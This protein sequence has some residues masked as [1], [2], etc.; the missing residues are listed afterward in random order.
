VIEG[1]TKGWGGISEAVAFSVLAFFFSQVVYMV[2]TVF[3]GL[4]VGLHASTISQVTAVGYLGFGGGTRPRM[5][6]AALGFIAG[7]VA[8][9]MGRSKI[10]TLGLAGFASVV[11]FFILDP[12]R[13]GDVFGQYALYN[14]T[15]ETNGVGAQASGGIRNL[16]G[17]SMTLFGDYITQG[18]FAQHGAALFYVGAIPFALYSKVGKTTSTLLGLF[19]AFI[20]GSGFVRIADMVPIKS[21]ASVLPGV[22]VGFGILVLF[23]LINIGETTLR[24]KF[25]R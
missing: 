21:V 15:G 14:F 9:R 11:L 19:A 18:Y 16:I 20:A 24:S 8:S 17:S 13:L 7:V 2:S 10:D 3:L 1:G 5:V 6:A 12:L 23:Y 25:I 22:A 4:P